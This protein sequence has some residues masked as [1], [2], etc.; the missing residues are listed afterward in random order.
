MVDWLS[1]VGASESLEVVRNLKIFI[2][3]SALRGRC[4]QKRCFL[5]PPQFVVNPTL[6]P[7]WHHRRCTLQL[8]SNTPSLL[9]SACSVPT[10]LSFHTQKK[11]LPCRGQVCHRIYDSVR[12]RYWCNYRIQEEC[13]QG[14]DPGD[15]ED[16][17]VDGFMELMTITAV[18]DCLQVMWRRQTIAI[19]KSKRGNHTHPYMSRRRGKNI[20]VKTTI[21]DDE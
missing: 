13:Q 5:A 16:R 7:L 18:T 19:M 9:N 21:S 3:F 10:F 4:G 11:S 17:Y 20:L 15:D 14:Y 12:Y 6:S 2:Y 8:Y 1:W